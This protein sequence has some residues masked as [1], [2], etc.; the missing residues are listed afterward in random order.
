MLLWGEA[1]KAAS[2]VFP[3]GE[4]GAANLSKTAGADAQKDVRWADA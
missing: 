2:G 1:G 4:F 3:K